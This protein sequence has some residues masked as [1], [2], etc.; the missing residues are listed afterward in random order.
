MYALWKIVNELTKSAEQRR[1]EREEAYLAEAVDL[2]DLEARMRDLD[3]QASKRTG[4][5]GFNA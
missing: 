4:W 1:L 2:Y 5:M 3:R